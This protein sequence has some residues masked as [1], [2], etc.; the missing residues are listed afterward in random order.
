MYLLLIF[1]FQSLAFALIV[2]SILTC[3]ATKAYDADQSGR[4]VAM[5]LLAVTAALT[6]CSVIYMQVATFR[7]ETKRMILVSFF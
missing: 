1:S 5:V 7:C 2:V 3:I 6:I 4:I